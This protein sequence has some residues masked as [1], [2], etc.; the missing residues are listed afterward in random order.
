MIKTFVDGVLIVTKED[1]SRTKLYNNPLATIPGGP[2]LSEEEAL[3]YDLDPNKFRF[4]TEE[5]DELEL[6]RIYKLS[7]PKSIKPTQFRKRL[8]NI[9]KL[10]DVLNI[11]AGLEDPILKTKLEI[12]LEYATDIYRDHEFITK[13]AP[14]LNMTEADIDIFF[15]EADK[16]K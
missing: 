16:I 1:G 8:L 3:A 7:V 5:E 4:T 11:I 2:W 15:I 6:Q 13:L 10:T 9:N 12:D 14:L